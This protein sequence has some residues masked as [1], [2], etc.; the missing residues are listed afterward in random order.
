MKVLQQAHATVV[1]AG[2]PCD[3]GRTFKSAINHAASCSSTAVRLCHMS[4][5]TWSQKGEWGLCYTNHLSQTDKNNPSHY[6]DIDLVEL[7]QII[8]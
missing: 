2:I 7:L 6:A 5:S 1:P 4:W 3:L 8:L